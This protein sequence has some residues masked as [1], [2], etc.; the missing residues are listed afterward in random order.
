[1]EVSA[2]IYG[3][4][5]YEVILLLFLNEGRKEMFYLTKHSTHFIYGYMASDIW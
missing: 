2:S 5:F 1:M 3:A 4:A